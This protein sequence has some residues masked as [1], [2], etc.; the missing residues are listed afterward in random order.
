MPDSGVL[1]VLKPERSKENTAINKGNGTNPGN[2]AAYSSFFSNCSAVLMP[3]GHLKKRYWSA[4]TDV[5]CHMLF[6]GLWLIMGYYT[7]F[8]LK[9]QN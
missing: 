8:W 2:T 7:I 1:K 5:Q 4:C 3:S 9:H 6:S